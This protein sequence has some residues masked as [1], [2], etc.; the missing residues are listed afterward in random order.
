MLKLLQH[1]APA[2]TSSKSAN[3]RSA[4]SNIF[5]QMKLHS[6]KQA[7]DLIVEIVSA[8]HKYDEQC[9]TNRQPRETME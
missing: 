2:T 5:A 6:Q 4:N 8:K 3:A 9:F 7:K 1:N